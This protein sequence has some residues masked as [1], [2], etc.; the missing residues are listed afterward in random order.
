M[1]LITWVFPLDSKL[2][3]KT[4]SAVIAR[5]GSDRLRLLKCL[6]GIA[7]GSPPGRPLHCFKDLYKTCSGLRPSPYNGSLATVAFLAM[8]LLIDR[9][10]LAAPCLQPSC[11]PLP[12]SIAYNEMKRKINNVI[13]NYCGTLATGKLWRVLLTNRLPV[14]LPRHVATAILDS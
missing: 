9:P 2:S 1:I 5:R 11:P 6:T 12:Y 13:K 10:R 14:N 8:N 7:W 4:H 3:W